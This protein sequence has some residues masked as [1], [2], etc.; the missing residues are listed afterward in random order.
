MDHAAK[1]LTGLDSFFL[2]HLREV[3]RKGVTLCQAEEPHLNVSTAKVTIY[4]LIKVIGSI[5]KILFF[6]YLTF[7][8]FCHFKHLIPSNQ[9]GIGKNT[10]YST[11]QN[12]VVINI[13]VQEKDIDRDT[14]VN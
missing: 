12:G 6:Y 7:N 10:V 14:P 2:G 5:Q 8:M 3:V 11:Y 13:S 1:P 4:I 9:L